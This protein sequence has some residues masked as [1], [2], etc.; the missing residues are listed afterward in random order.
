VGV[1]YLKRVQKDKIW[2]HAKALLAGKREEEK[3]RGLGSRK[4]AKDAKKNLSLGFMKS[5]K[6]FARRGRR[7]PIQA[8]RRGPQSKA[9]D[10][11]LHKEINSSPLRGEVRRG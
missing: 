2:V 11:G 3:G 9:W 4:A 10:L 5:D 6:S 1:S 8:D 7:P